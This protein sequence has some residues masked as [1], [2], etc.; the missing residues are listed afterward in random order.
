MKVKPDFITKKEKFDS[1]NHR[2]RTK[3]ELHH[4]VSRT[5]LP[6]QSITSGERRDL[7]LE[8][9]ELRLDR[10]ALAFWRACDGAGDRTLPAT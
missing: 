7:A 6:F 4:I 2:C 1:D 9:V 8:D 5:L 3:N 10:Q